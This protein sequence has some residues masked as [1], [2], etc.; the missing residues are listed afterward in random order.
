MQNEII[1]S[2]ELLNING[3]LTQKGWA[4]EL[5]LHYN[6][7]NIRTSKLKIKEWDYYCIL[8]EKFGVAFTIA[9]NGYIGLISITLLDFLIPTQWTKTILIPF[10][11]GKF[12]MPSTSHK[13]NVV[14]NNKKCRLEFIKEGEYRYLKV[15]IKEF[16]KVDTLEGE[17]TLHQPNNL[18]SMV[19]ATPFYKKHRFYYNQKINCMKAY[20][21]LILGNKNYN[22]NTIPSFGVL[23]WGRGVWTYSNKWYW[24]SLSGTI[25]N[26]SFGFNIGY[27][28][29]DTSNA[30][31]NMLFYK[32]KAHKLD[33][34]T[35]VIPNDSYVKPWTFTSNDNR[36]EMNFDPIIDRHSNSN[37]LVIKSNQ[38]QV[39][40]YYS[41]KVILDSGQELKVNNLLG[42]AEEVTN[43]W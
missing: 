32:D 27:G 5:L 4:K 34:V 6:R 14:Y 11:L 36:F 16:N 7:P 10:P 29:G 24:G 21:N 39:F 43:R 22:F 26:Q 13:G 42:F 17:I 8:N 25:N 35:F 2:G 33:K 3:D 40:G 1:H 28:F 23:D 15:N 18:E 20:G 38:H 31:E 41:G 9:D 19:I 12:N 30:S 37:I